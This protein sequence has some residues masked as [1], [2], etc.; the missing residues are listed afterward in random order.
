MEELNT[1]E[2]KKEEKTNK[3][4]IENEQE[5]EKRRTLAED[6]S[7]MTITQKRVI[8]VSSVVALIIVIAFIV[9]AIINKL[10]N[11][12]YAGITFENIDL[13]GMT[14]L[15]ADKALTDYANEVYNRS[16][17]VYQ[18]DKMLFEVSAEDLGL[19][20]DVSQSQ[21]D[22]AE[23]ARQ[24][25]IFTNNFNVI[26]AWLMGVN[27]KVKYECNAQKV[28]VISSKLLSQI[29]GSVIDDTYTVSENKLIITKGTK[30]LDIDKDEIIQDLVKML[31]GKNDSGK[32]DRYDIG[33]SEREPKKLDV[34]VVYATVHKEAID[35][36]VDETVT[37]A[38]YVKHEN[39]IDFD[40]EKL[41]EV[42]S[43][44]ENSVEGKVIE[45]E[46]NITEPAVKLGDLKW[47]LYSDLLG[48]YSTTFS[49]AATY[50]NRNTNIRVSAE[51][52][53][54]TIVMPGETFSFNKTVGDCGS[55]SRG[56]KMATVYSNGKVEQGMGGGVCQVSSTLYN[57]VIYANLDIV[58][59]DNHGFT[60]SYVPCSRDAT[61]YYPYLDFK[62]K[63]TRNYPIKI[64]AEYSSAGKITFSI[65]GTK[66]D[67]EYEVA[68]ESYILTRIP[69]STTY[70]NDNTIEKGKTVQD[71]IG[72]DGFTS[73]AYKVLKKDGKVVSK[74]VLSSDSYSPMNDVIKVGT[75]EV[76][77]S[78]YTE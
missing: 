13:S 19:K 37:P 47:E 23:F 68:I 11:N 61:I 36:K 26:K 28:A 30:G 63:N 4:N 24:G 44:E 57:A 59:R 35:A 34:D 16:V 38:V 49:T 69:K 39:G 17:L 54:G 58:Q 48:T 40:K 60:V 14:V 18:N 29:E 65:Y 9:I 41:R 77:V 72:Q 45:F 42:L 70:V 32:V 31:I 3:E 73:I 53:N 78:P 1:K 12:I 55:A 8:I 46:L 50:A 27:F 64:V 51:Y 2:Q 56:F 21:K 67:N 10:N 74:T 5:S 20:V 25:N 66:E 52:I 15:E 22:I 62:F 43:L 75:K 71:I 33:T 7:G 76:V 6:K